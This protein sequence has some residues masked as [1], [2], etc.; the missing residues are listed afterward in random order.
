MFSI[1]NN[2]FII[3]KYNYI[4]I[5]IQLYIYIHIH[6]DIRMLVHTVCFFQFPVHAKVK[7]KKEPPNFSKKASFRA[8][9]DFFF[10]PAEDSRLPKADARKTKNNVWGKIFPV[11]VI[12]G[13]VHCRRE[14]PMREKKNES[15]QFCV[16]WVWWVL[17]NMRLSEIFFFKQIWVNRYTLLKVGIF[18]YTKTT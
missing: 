18:V 14:R 7:K 11:S 6:V 17:V 8:M 13:V 4:D 3:Y 15:E 10:S 2:I 9:W 5:D 12:W 16:W 1:Y